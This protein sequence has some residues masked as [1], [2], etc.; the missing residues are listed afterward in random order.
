MTRTPYR[1]DVLT[2]MEYSHQPVLTLYARLE[3]MAPERRP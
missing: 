3:R 2:A 1:N